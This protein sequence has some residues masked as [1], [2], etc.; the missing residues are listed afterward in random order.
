MTDLTPLPR[1]APYTIKELAERWDCSTETIL[2]KI[3]KGDLPCIEIGPRK[4]LVPANDVLEHESART[5]RR[6]SLSLAQKETHTQ[7]TTPS[8]GQSDPPVSPQGAESSQRA[9]LR[10][11]ARGTR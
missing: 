1:E 2:R 10:N 7:S 3:R 4:L 5:G 8:P 6:A 11:R 9:K